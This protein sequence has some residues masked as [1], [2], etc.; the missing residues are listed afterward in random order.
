[1]AGDLEH[2]GVIS[3]GFEVAFN[4]FVVQMKLSDARKHPKIKVV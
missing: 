4:S 1:M 2:I 3:D